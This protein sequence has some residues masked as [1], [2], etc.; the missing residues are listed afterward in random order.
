MKK[1]FRIFTLSML[2]SLAACSTDNA[3]SSDEGSTVD[4]QGVEVSITATAYGSP[5]DPYDVEIRILSDSK[6]A[7]AERYTGTGTE[8]I[9]ESENVTGNLIEVQFQL[10]NFNP[11][12]KSGGEGTG[13]DRIV[14]KIEDHKKFELLLEEDVQ[15]LF[16]S[17]DIVY[18]VNLIYN[19]ETDELEY[20]YF[21]F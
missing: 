5:D 11:D 6:V 17:T 12:T 21:S 13:L 1:L 2:C 10:M 15:S 3:E 8:V 14:V 18:Q 9:T 19:Q 20:D 4:E 7:W 16:V